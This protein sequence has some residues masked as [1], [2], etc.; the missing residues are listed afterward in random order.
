MQL[1]LI[2]V[3]FKASFIPVFQHEK[4][5]S[6]WLKLFNFKRLLFIWASMALK[7]L[8]LI[9]DI[10]SIFNNI[11]L[12]QLC[13]LFSKNSLRIFTLALF[14]L[15]ASIA[16]VH[17]PLWLFSKSWCYEF[18]SLFLLRLNKIIYYYRRAEIF[19][20]ELINHSN[21]ILDRSRNFICNIP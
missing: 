1:F 9:F 11:F 2:S 7:E 8:W 21:S 13:F 6:K 4:G 19:I 16:D 17:E 5:E 15:L 12:S 14:F 20:S 3:G 10:I 18:S